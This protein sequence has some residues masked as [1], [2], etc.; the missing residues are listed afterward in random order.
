MIRR[1]VTGLSAVV[2]LFMASSAVSQEDTALLYK[3]MQALKTMSFDI[4]Q[5]LDHLERSP[6]G[7]T[8][9][10][11]RVIRSD[12]NETLKRITA[13]LAVLEQRYIKSIRS[14]PASTTTPAAKD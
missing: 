7:L 8:Q 3:G 2:M 1:L 6:K 10:D 12:L 13:D 11:I 9:E 5:E 14:Q 4:N